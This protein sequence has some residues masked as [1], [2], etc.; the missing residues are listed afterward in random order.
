MI[1]DKELGVRLEGS[2]TLA[3]SSQ[4]EDRW[5]AEQEG[6]HSG[7]GG[8][9]HPQ[10]FSVTDKRSP[11]TSSLKGPTRRDDITLI[12]AKCRT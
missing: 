12:V 6:G 10:F 4:D 7:V 9:A 1:C 5:R 2:A 8:V 3:A 11:Y